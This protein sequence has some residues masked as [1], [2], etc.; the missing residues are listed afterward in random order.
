ML[1]GAW[2]YRYAYNSLFGWLPDI[3]G[4][5]CSL[6]G[7]LALSVP[8]CTTPPPAPG[9][10]PPFGGS[11]HIVNG[12]RD[13]HA[14]KCSGIEN[15][16]RPRVFHEDGCIPLAIPGSK[17]PGRISAN[18]P[19]P[20]PPTVPPG[21]NPPPQTLGVPKPLPNSNPPANW[22]PPPNSSGTQ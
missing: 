5:V 7:P 4:S 20:A 13:Q 19:P 3:Q 10:H 22:S 9:W 16:R 15:R 12:V 11:T 6:L 1:A 21:W 8:L 14:K 2:A 18:P 17:P